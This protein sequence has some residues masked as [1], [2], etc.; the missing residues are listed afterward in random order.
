MAITKEQLDQLR[1]LLRPLATRIANTVARAVVRFVDDSKK[2]Q[3]VQLGVL[4]DE[5]VA[6]ASGSGCEH[7]QPYGFFS[8]PHPGAE[9][10]VI[11]PNGDRT[12]PLVIA[13]TD[14]RYRPTGGKTGEVGLRT[15]E[16]DEIRLARDHAMVL[17][18]TGQIQL[19]GVGAAS[20]AVLGD[21]Q[22]SALG[23]LVTTIGSAV[24]SIPGGSAAGAQITAA[25]ATFQ[26][27]APRFLSARVKLE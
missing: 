16:G 23:T 9:A 20:P 25:L 21:Q 4:A 22:L 26:A 6:G 18:T 5:P 24:G 17:T 11:F 10:A 13:V 8:V 27:A 19:G 1:H 12:H 15:D 3:L 2:M 14:R 7:F